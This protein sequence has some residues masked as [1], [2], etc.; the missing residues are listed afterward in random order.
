MDI[1]L[2]FFSFY[3]VCTSIFVLVLISATAV[4]G[5]TP[6]QSPTTEEFK[7]FSETV[8][9]LRITDIKKSTQSQPTIN[10]IQA[11]DLEQAKPVSRKFD[12]Q[13]PI[14]EQKIEFLRVKDLEKP[15]PPETF[16]KPLNITDKPLN[17]TESPSS[18][19][20]LIPPID[21]KSVAA[22]WGI[23]PI[24]ILVDDRM[25]VKSALVRGTED[26]SQAIQFDDWLIPY[27]VMI[28]ALNIRVTNLPN[29]QVQLRS[30]TVVFDLDFS[31][32]R[33]D[34]EIGAVLSIRDVKDWFGIAPEFDINNYAIQIKYPRTNQSDLSKATVEP[35]IDLTNIPYIFA[36]SFT[37][38]TI[39]N[40]ES[41]Q[42]F[43]SRATQNRTLTSSGSLLG[44]AWLL[45]LNET[46][47]ENEN[48]WRLGSAS[49]TL[50]KDST[51]L[52]VG[53]QS[54]F[55]RSTSPNPFWGVTTVQR[56]GLTMPPSNGGSAK[57]RVQPS[58]FGQTIRGKAAP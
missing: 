50:Q 19:N 36:P 44:G 18:A 20:S 51:D 13:F 26:G 48:S 28:K 33:L 17:I 42:S 9:F 57:I 31:R 10:F 52:F 29:G 34:P 8:E 43:R 30:P 39:N 21:P 38:T 12:D 2:K 56:W 4:F 25:V 7:K 11:V 22:Q 54:P 58:R 24:G 55:W 1:E 47:T 6:G 49:Y 46:Q 35:P 27:E 14:N 3:S 15:I 32:L 41:G 5:K 37:V 40:E 16:N 45:S 53:S 23:L